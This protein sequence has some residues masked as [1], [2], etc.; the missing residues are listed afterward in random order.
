[1]HTQWQY[2]KLSGPEAVGNKGKKFFWLHDFEL[3][4]SFPFANS[5]RNR[6]SRCYKLARII[7]DAAV[8]LSSHLDQRKSRTAQ[9]IANCPKSHELP[10]TCVHHKI[11]SFKTKEYDTQQPQWIVP[12]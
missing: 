12:K 9:K 6:L 3:L 10:I 7:N 2:S 8:L 11:L 1:M 4:L 5:R